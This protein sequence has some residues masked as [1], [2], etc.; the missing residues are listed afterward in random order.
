MDLSATLRTGAP[1]P[2]DTVFYYASSGLTGVRRGAFKL[3]QAMAAGSGAAGAP[4]PVPPPRVWEL[5][6]LD[7]DPSEKFDLASKRPEIVSE[8]MALIE[9]HR[10][11]VE[12][13]ENQIP[14][15]RGRGRGAAPARG[16]GGAP[17]SP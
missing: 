6:N 10:K 2:R 14:L 1:S 15:G 5:Y 11:T 17:A 4:A 8:L 9:Q 13:G 12:P 7:E 3:H 16:S